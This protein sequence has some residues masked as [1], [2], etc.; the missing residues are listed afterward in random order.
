M[1]K[2]S[3][4]NLGERQQLV[5]YLLKHNSMRGPE[6]YTIINSH[7][8]QLS[9][10][11]EGLKM[12]QSRTNCCQMENIKSTISLPYQ[13]IIKYAICSHN[14]IYFVIPLS[15]SNA[16]KYVQDVFLRET[17]LLNDIGTS[18]HPSH[19]LPPKYPLSEFVRA[20]EA[21]NVFTNL[22]RMPAAIQSFSRAEIHHTLSSLSQYYCNYK[23]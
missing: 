1:R 11:W 4:G 7:K 3:Q 2:I 14:K 9:L 13:V 22:R 8:F 21:F 16:E 23:L 10:K 17:K 5:S 20:M 15:G 19:Q 6:A 12:S 18:E